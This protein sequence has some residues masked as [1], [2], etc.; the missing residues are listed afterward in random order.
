LPRHS[1]AWL[2]CEIE[3]KAWG[4]GTEIFTHWSQCK[5]LDLTEHTSTKS[6]GMFKKVLVLEKPRT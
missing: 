4:Q 1:S 5:A 2:A 3:R 6:L